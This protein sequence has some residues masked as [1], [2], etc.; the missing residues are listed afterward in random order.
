MEHDLSWPNLVFAAVS[1]LAAFYLLVP[2]LI[3][4]SQRMNG[5]PRVVLF[6][7][8]QTPPPER[9]AAYFEDAG[10]SL[11]GLGFE[12]YSCVALPDPMPNVRALCQVWVHAERRDAALV[13]AIFG[14]ASNGPGM[15][16]CYTELLSRFTDDDLAAVQTNNATMVSAFPVLPNERTFRFPQVRSIGELD[17]LHRRLLEREAP[18][19]RK[20]V[21]LL[22]Q[23]HGDLVAYFRWAL[24]ESY[25]KQ[26]STGYLR[27]REEADHWRPTV[28][29]AYLMTWS[30]LW[31]MSAIARARIRGHGRRLQQELLGADA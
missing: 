25:R 12:P 9:I 1:L 7:L 10:E 15:E 14:I 19:S 23:F 2:W 29:G 21:T 6:D 8:E 3:Y 4:F 17:R 28:K 24:T 30:Q 11:L 13:S 27:R 22:D 31:P 26:E 20:T 16:T 5:N 18:A